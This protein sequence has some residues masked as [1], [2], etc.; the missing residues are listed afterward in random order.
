[1]ANAHPDVKCV[2]DRIIT[3][4]DSCGVAALIDELLG[5]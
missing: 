3:D 5:P 1:M 2:A 4:N